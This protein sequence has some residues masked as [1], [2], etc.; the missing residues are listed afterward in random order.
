M[1]LLAIRTLI[2][3]ELDDLYWRTC[4]TQGRSPG[5]RDLCTGRVEHDLGIFLLA[6]RFDEGFAR[7]IAT[8]IHDLFLEL[9]LHF[10]EGLIGLHDFEHGLQIAIARGL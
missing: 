3:S 7:L 2:V 8:A 9:V 5:R 6:Q 4:W 1:H 10:L